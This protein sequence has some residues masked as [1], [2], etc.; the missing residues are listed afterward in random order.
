MRGG[1]VALGEPRGGRGL[2]P[3]EDV[4]GQRRALAALEVRRPDLLEAHVLE[5][6]LLRA[7]HGAPAA[8]LWRHPTA[9]GLAAQELLLLLPL[10]LKLLVLDLFQFLGGFDLGL[11]F[12]LLAHL[13]RGQMRKRKKKT[14]ERERKRHLGVQRQR[15]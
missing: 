8:G 13:L 3:E 10:L 4:V 14:K 6:R 7:H 12:A 5:G 1:R 15:G 2:R 11:L 9:E